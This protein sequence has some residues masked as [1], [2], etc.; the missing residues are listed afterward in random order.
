MQ[1]YNPKQAAFPDPNEFFIRLSPASS[2][3]AQVWPDT[4]PQID[5]SN[6]KADDSNMSD[7]TGDLQQSD[8]SAIEA[9]LAKNPRNNVYLLNGKPWHVAT[10]SDY[11][12][13]SLPQVYSALMDRQES[14]P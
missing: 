8:Y 13:P 7:L 3:K 2:S 10:Q 1:Y 5:D 9:M 6:L 11:I 14:A 12:L 4:L